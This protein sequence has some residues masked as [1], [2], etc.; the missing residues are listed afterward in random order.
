MEAARILTLRGHKASIYEKGSK[1]GGVFNAAAAP[2]FKEADKAL[3]AWY[4]KQMKELG[5]DV[6]FGTEVTKDVIEGETPDAVIVA[7][8]AAPRKL[9]FKGE[10]E[11]QVVSAIDF[12][13]GNKAVGKNIIVVGGGL[14]GCEIAYDIARKGGNV[15]L[16]EMTDKILAAPL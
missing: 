14:T 9:S 16:V 13:L 4:E 2:D 1:L 8:G 12:L 5:I 6:H 15:T 7:S 11:G 3:L 10:A